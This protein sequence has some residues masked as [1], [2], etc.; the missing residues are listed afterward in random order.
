[1]EL[2][3]TKIYHFGGQNRKN[4]IF[5]ALGQIQAISFLFSHP[6]KTKKMMKIK[7]SIKIIFYR[8][9]ETGHVI[10]NKTGDS[11]ILFKQN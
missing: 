9:R 8:I 3:G 4:D 11:N 1:M 10:P 2:F 6:I 5:L 7:F